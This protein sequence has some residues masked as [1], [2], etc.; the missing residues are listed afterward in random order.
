VSSSDWPKQS[1]SLTCGSRSTVSVDRSTIN[2]DRATTGLGWAWAGPD[3]GR[4]RPA[5]CQALVLPRHLNGFL[6]RAWVHKADLWWTGGGGSHAATGSTV[7]HVHFPLLSS[8]ST[9]RWVYRSS[10]SLFPH[11]IFTGARPPAACLPGG[12]PRWLSS[13]AKVSYRF[14]AT[15]G[16]RR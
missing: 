14:V 12:A 10:R 3:L 8:R 9:V 11:S 1:E 6:D 4:A 13:A 5:T 15:K 7:D 2:V 16:A